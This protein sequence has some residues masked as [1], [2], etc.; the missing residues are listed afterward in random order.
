MNSIIVGL[1]I[2]NLYKTQL[3]LLGHNVITV[4]LDPSKQATF[5]DINHALDNNPCFE[6]AFICTPNFTHFSLANKL[7][8]FSKIVFVEK[9]GVET[10][11]LWYDL[12]TSNPKTRFMMVKNNQWRD[13]IDEFKSLAE[14]S[15]KIYLHW[16]NQNRVPNPGSWFTNR[17]LA[18]GGVSRDL[19]PHL[20]SLYITLEPNYK[21]TGW[22]KRQ[23][24]QRWRLEDLSS[25]G[26]G[27]IDP[28]GVY[29]VDDRAELYTVINGKYYGI[30]ADWRSNGDNDI[31]I[32]FDKEY[33]EL[34]LCPESAYKA[35][36]ETALKNIDN[37]D[38]W[39]D[40]NHQD[41]WI[42]DVITTF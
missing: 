5:T 30:V 18:F 40:Q 36:I 15:E 22:L 17:K 16:I 24:Y 35:M 2:G 31:G 27:V 19:I 32:H 12:I 3:E 21:Q 25:T 39:I 9:P 33:R 1:G 14:K 42:H 28:L 26:Y 13:N 10:S 4:D 6:T 29:D 8:K 20:L 7:A 11:S 41:L 23:F 38:F 34:G 37:K